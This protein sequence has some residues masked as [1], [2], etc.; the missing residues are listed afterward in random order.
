YQ[1]PFS[2]NF[3]RKGAC[4]QFI[5]SCVF[6]V[7]KPPDRNRIHLSLPPAYTDMYTTYEGGIPMQHTQQDETI[8][9][10]EPKED[11]DDLIF[12]ADP[13]WMVSER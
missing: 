1:R 13:G 8:L 10:T 7:K 11:I 6:R 4:S 2:F 5:Y 9:R 12:R 3:T